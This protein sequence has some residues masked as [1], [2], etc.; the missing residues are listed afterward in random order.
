MNKIPYQKPKYMEAMFNCPLCNAFAHQTWSIVLYQPDLNEIFFDMDENI[1]ILDTEHLLIINELHLCFCSCCKKCS[2]WLGDK[3]IYPKNTNIA[4]PNP[5]LT[6]DIKADYNE[7]SLILQDSPRGAAALLRLAVQKLC[8]QL[9]EKGDNI[10]D[11]ISNLVINKGLPVELQQAL[12]SLRVIGNET[13]HPGEMDLKDNTET[14]S[15][16]FEI[17]NYIADRM[18]T[19]PKKLNEI[20]SSLPETK[21]KA[22]EKRD[23]KIK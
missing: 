22:I 7:A 12:D 20:Y 10:S 8:K 3:M 18:I 15:S 13:V 2:I 23:S 21:I 1:P 11:D 9:G 5:D 16:L 17:L 14:A 19:Q 6:D 4:L